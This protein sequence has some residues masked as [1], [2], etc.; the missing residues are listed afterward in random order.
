MLSH[1][2]TVEAVADCF[3]KMPEGRVTYRLKEGAGKGNLPLLSYRDCDHQP[4]EETCLSSQQGEYTQPRDSTNVA[5]CANCEA[6][7]WKYYD[8][9]EV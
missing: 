2:G 5:L 4:R 6:A 8:K 7:L 3:E 9:E 1:S